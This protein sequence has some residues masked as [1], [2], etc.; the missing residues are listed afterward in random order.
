[1]RKIV[2]VGASL[3]GVTAADRLR[4]LGYDGAL[5]LIGD[6]TAPP[7]DRP[8][9]SIDFLAS[10]LAAKVSLRE[11]AHFHSSEITLRLGAVATGLNV[12]A[13]ELSL[14][15]G[16][17]VAYDGLII[18]TGARPRRPA[19]LLPGRGAC[20]LRTLDDALALSKAFQRRPRLVVVG[21]GFIGMEVATQAC[22]AALDVTVVEPQPYPMFRALG[23]E[24]GTRMSR[25]L[26]NRGAKV[27][28]GLSVDGLV[29]EPAVQ[30]VRLSDGS[31]IPADLVLVSIGSVPN[32][33]WLVGSS[34][35]L[36]DGI[37]CD[38]FCQAAPGIFAAGDVAARLDA[39]RG[40]RVRAE[41]WTSAVEDAGIAA[42][43]M[44]RPREEWRRSS[45][46][47]Y[48]WSDQLG[49][50]LQ[51][52]G[53]RPPQSVEHVIDHKDERRFAACYQAGGRI[54]AIAT[55][56]WPVLLARGRALIAQS[57]DWNATLGILEA[58]SVPRR[59]PA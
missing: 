49:G 8:P 32:S 41:H 43:N 31:E 19:F 46:V 56:D 27:L 7:Y 36:D 25:M 45:G 29:G 53:L 12:A 16:E 50:K 28:L 10:D 14:T 5:E 24:A 59:Q 22:Q 20:F 26:Q 3:A 34:L 35:P 55:F 38:E 33:D 44:L 42:H 57:V 15:D 37:L 18:A 6:E 48:V 51:I 13:R 40:R 1:M 2:V 30:G 21:A 17:T 11:P 52:A 23:P 9:L 58:Q 39:L 4:E 47:A 54:C